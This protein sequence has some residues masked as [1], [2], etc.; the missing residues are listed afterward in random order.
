MTFC[1]VYDAFP[2]AEIALDPA[3]C[4]PSLVSLQSRPLTPHL[5]LCLNPNAQMDDS[6]NEINAIQ[7]KMTLSQEISSIA[8][9]VSDFVEA[10]SD[11]ETGSLHFLIAD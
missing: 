5:M 4:I 3:Y 9:P 1:L 7:R 10:E 11:V 6:Y 8:Q 2:E